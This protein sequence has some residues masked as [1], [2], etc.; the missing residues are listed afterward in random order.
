VESS[1]R[2]S[3]ALLLSDVILDVANQ[4]IFSFSEEKVNRL[5]QIWQGDVATLLV[6]LAFSAFVAK[7]GEDPR[8][9]APSSSSRILRFLN[10]NEESLY[11]LNIVFSL[12]LSL[13]DS[14][15]HSRF[16]LFV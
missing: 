14:L 12:S 3:T 5:R 7:F 13:S 9:H 6:S 8:T 11:H 10:L 1:G 16:I 4:N 2:K 15:M